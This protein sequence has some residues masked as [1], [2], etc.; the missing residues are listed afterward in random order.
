MLDALQTDPV[1]FTITGVHLRI[2]A[3]ILFT[4]AVVGFFYGRRYRTE[5][6]SPLDIPDAW[7]GALIA[8]GMAIVALAADR[9]LLP[10]GEGFPIFWYGI[11]I[12]LGIAIGAWWAGREIERRGG[13][14]D[15]FYNGLL[16][17]I[18]AGYIFARLWYVL[19]EVIAGRGAEYETFIDIINIRA[20]GANI[21]GG[22]IGAALVAAWYIRR[23]R[24]NFWK[25]ADVAGPALLIAQAIG[26]WGNFINQELYGPPTEQ[27]WGI[28]IDP[29][30]RI[31]PFNNLSLYPADTRFHPTFLYESIWLFVGF[32]LLVY[33]N[34]RFR[35]R[36][37]DGTLFG[38]FL[39]W[40][41]GGRAWIELFRPDQPAFGESFVTYSM[42]IA[43]LIALAGV[44]V[45]LYR[46]DKLPES[47]RERRRRRRRLRKPK[48][49]RS[50]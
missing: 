27:P 33:L 5:G 2:A 34:H 18:I 29:A 40:W 42:V 36:W 17:V 50:E 28:L 25:Y 3:I 44:L 8:L 14:V 7:F 49:N 16:L 4:L 21:L 41:G 12:T 6:E 9:L 23:K 32:F 39:I 46:Y 43:L 38:L 48:P 13:D 20:G 26:R 11:L 24:L 47:G 15:T 31:P 35:E 1:A 10:E 30:N 19:Q 22:F 45:L 37:K